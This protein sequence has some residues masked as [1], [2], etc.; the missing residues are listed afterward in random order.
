MGNTYLANSG[1]M[2]ICGPL[3][4]VPMLASLRAAVYIAPGGEFAFV[5]YGLAAA[6][7]LLPMAI[8][9]QINLA[10]VLTMAMTPLFAR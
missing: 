2:A 8:V 5:T 6:A 7:G 4:G 10:V 9:N 3:F 1:V